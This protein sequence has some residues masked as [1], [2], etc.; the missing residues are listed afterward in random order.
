MNT[1]S[2]YN[3]YPQTN[4]SILIILLLLSA[5]QTLKPTTPIKSE[6]VEKMDASE[7]ELIWIYHLAGVLCETTYYTSTEEAVT[8]LDSLEVRVYDSFQFEI[9]SCT[10]CGC[11]S[12]KRFA[13]N[14]RRYDLSRAIAMG[15]HF[16]ED[17]SVIE[18]NKRQ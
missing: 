8:T 17:D 9:P 4:W 18:K 13:A 14:I 11:P 12:S 15:W 2:Y 6:Y 10:S 3:I 7:N 1:P 16:L 5:C